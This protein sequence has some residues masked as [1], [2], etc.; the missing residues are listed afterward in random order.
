MNG[1]KKSMKNSIP[2]LCI[3]LN[4]RILWYYFLLDTAQCTQGDVSW[5]Q[6]SAMRLSI[7]IFLPVILFI[8]A[9]KQKIKIS[10][11]ILVFQVVVLMIA[12]FE[13]IPYIIFMTIRGIALC[14]GSDNWGGFDNEYD[15]DSMH[16]VFYTIERI[17]PIIF[18]TIP[19]LM[20]VLVILYLLKKNI[21]HAPFKNDKYL[22]PDGRM[23]GVYN[24]ETGKIVKNNDTKG[25][26]NFY[27]PNTQP[28]NHKKVDVEPY[29]KWG[30]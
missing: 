22:A 27:D 21:F 18:V 15:L 8:T 17:L 24:K 12:L 9:I 14:H 25:T 26:F 4:A 30:N 23:E 2:F 3:Y 5:Y 11:M 19:V 7:L 1:L 13:S 16:V 28:S 10:W 29:M 20:L 6:Y